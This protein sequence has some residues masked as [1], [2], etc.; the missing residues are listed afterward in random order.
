MTL[1]IAFVLLVGFSALVLF[2][3]EKLRVDVVALLVMVTFIG[4][5]VLSPT[6]GI[7]G[8]SNPATVTVAAMFVIAQALNN[9]GALDTVAALLL[10]L[11]R[12]SLNRAA[13]FLMSSIAFISAFI[14]NTAAV[15][16]FLPVTIKLS[17]SARTSPS[18]LLIPLSYASL[19]GGVCTL[20][21]TS[22]NILVSTLSEQYG[23]QP[24]GMFEMTRLGLILASIGIIYM[25]LIG[26]PLLPERRQIQ[27]LEEEFK[28][29]PYLTEIILREPSSLVGMDLNEA[30]LTDSFDIDVLEIQRGAQRIRHPDRYTTLEDGDLLRIRCGRD[31]LAE[32]SMLPGVELCPLKDGVKRL[33]GKVAEAVV[34]P[35]SRLVGQTLKSIN[36]RDRFRCTTVA[37]RRRGKT[38]YSKLG[39]TVLQAG[40]VLLLVGVPEALMEKRGHRDFVL[41]SKIRL[42]RQR[43]HLSIPSVVVIALVVL[44]VSF[45]IVP[46]VVGALIGCAALLLVGSIT[47]DEMYESI[48]WSVIMLIGGMLTLGAAVT[49]S[50]ADK[51]IAGFLVR[52]AGDFGPWVLLSV[53]YLLTSILTEGL[54]N[55]A[56]A[57]LLVPLAISTAQGMGVDP[58]PFL[59]A[60]TFA[61]SNSFMT[62]VGYQTNTL[63]YGPGQ[64]RVSDYLKVGV[65]LNLLFWIVATCLIPYFWPFNP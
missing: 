37:L 12:R 38:I 36:F 65:P 35:G 51:L 50:G 11:A 28:I 21:G 32:L 63:V 47:A 29:T 43:R 13:L 19:F 7:A 49:E 9:T 56:T 15:A 59:M 26:I 52:I 25:L 27:D 2:V 1:E 41:V 33:V 58:R 16:V 40:D 17:G 22:T 60:I 42:N 46:V 34:A 20:I 8:F 48:D 24:I 5:G 3:S 4:T 53:L 18:K 44:S 39:H 10:K 55:S 45:K 14:N 23:Y 31:T 57:V 61:A 6:Q 64:Y 54:S 62:P 30:H